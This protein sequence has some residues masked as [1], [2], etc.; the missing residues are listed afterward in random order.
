ML[1]AVLSVLS[2]PFMT[3]VPDGAKMQLWSSTAPK[4]QVKNGAFYTPAGNGKEYTQAILKNDKLAN[5]LWDWT[6]KEFAKHGY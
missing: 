4:N 5:E 6:E 3:S 2:G 1:G